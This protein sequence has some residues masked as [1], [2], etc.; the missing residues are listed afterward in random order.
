MREQL[1]DL[2]VPFLPLEAR[3]VLLCARDTCGN[4]EL[5]CSEAALQE[6]TAALV[7]VPKEQPLFSAQGCKSVSQRLSFLSP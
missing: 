7:S 3:H 5:P 6:L 1:I 4:R 2:F